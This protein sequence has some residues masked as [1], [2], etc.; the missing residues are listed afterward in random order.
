MVSIGHNVSERSRFSNH[1]GGRKPLRNAADPLRQF[2]LEQ[3]AIRHVL[4][5]TLIVRFICDLLFEGIVDSSGTRL[6]VTPKLRPNEIGQ[7]FVGVPIGTKHQ[8][9]S[10]GEEEFMNTGYCNTDCMAVRTPFP[11]PIEITDSRVTFGMKICGKIRV[12]STPTGSW[13]RSGR[14]QN[15]IQLPVGVKNIS[16]FSPNFHVK[17]DPNMT[18][19]LILRLNKKTN[20]PV[21]CRNFH[22]KGSSS[23]AAYFTLIWQVH[24]ADNGTIT[25]LSVEKTP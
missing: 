7:M 12:V 22:R 19:G 23:L 9:I 25:V 5:F 3:T 16:N 13:T 2:E 14:K 18:F 20:W 6:Y 15:R 8:I 11:E 17:S 4:L 1:G 21:F 24:G 10:P